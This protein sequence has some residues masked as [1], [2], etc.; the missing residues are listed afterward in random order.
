MT[1]KGPLPSTIILSVRISKYEFGGGRGGGGGGTDIQSIA[2]TVTVLR[3]FIYLFLKSWPFLFLL[4][5]KWSYKIFLKPKYYHVTLI[6]FILSTIQT[7]CMKPQHH[8]QSS[9]PNVPIL[10]SV[11]LSGIVCTFQ[12]ITSYNIKTSLFSSSFALAHTLFLQ[13]SLPFLFYLLRNSYCN[14]QIYLRC[15]VFYCLNRVNVPVSVL[16]FT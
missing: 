14:F 9:L 8:S 7:I 1:F 2:H 6:S 15:F 10:S 4:H 5:C 11:T 16:L 3:H 13:L 12:I